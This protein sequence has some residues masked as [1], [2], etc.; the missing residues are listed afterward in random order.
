M[1]SEFNRLKC[2][3]KNHGLKPKNWGARQHYLRYNVAK[4]ARILECT[5]I[6]YDSSLTFAE[7]AGFR[8]GCCY[9]YPL[10]DFINR[11]SLKIRERPLIIMDRSV[12]APQYMNL[13]FDE[14]FNF[15]A[16]CKRRCQLYKGD[17]TILWHNNL[18]IK[19]QYRE[20]YQSI[21]ET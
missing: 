19:N 9:E 8:C 5:G 13:D 15:M 11:R 16:K 14:A 10:F 12:L 7:N 1:Q 4:T 2:V 3:C 18:L 17:F 20:L 6:T 21:L